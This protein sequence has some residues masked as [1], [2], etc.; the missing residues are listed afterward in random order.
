MN[1][2][3][4]VTRRDALVLVRL[5]AALTDMLAD[6]DGLVAKPKKRRKPAARRK[7]A[8][9]TT[10]SVSK[11]ATRAAAARAKAARLASEDAE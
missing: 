4:I 2:A 6:M 10:P 11:A 8:P 7:V 1:T 3:T 9:S 5:H